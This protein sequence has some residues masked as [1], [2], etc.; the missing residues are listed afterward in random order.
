MVKFTLII[1]VSLLAMFSMNMNEGSGFDF[2]FLFVMYYVSF[3]ILKKVV[4]KK[5]KIK[6]F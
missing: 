1:L 4:K 3:V 5:L 2:M 6:K